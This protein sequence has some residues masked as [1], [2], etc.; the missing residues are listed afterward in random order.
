MVAQSVGDWAEKW[1]VLSLSLSFDLKWSKRCFF[2]IV[3]KII[4]NFWTN[5]HFSPNKLLNWPHLCRIIQSTTNLS[6][7]VC[8]VSKYI[9]AV[10]G[11]WK[12]TQRAYADTTKYANSTERP[13]TAVSTPWPSGIFESS[14][15]LW[16]LSLITASLY[17]QHCI[18][19]MVICYYYYYYYYLQVWYFIFSV[20]Y[21]LLHCKFGQEAV[22]KL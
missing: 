15:P 12:Y 1:R 9:S 19:A 4:N 11:D 13:F 3:L 22:G 18:P 20:T 10:G 14:S 17:L 6:S 16:S 2:L 7:N 21:R 5:F 8:E